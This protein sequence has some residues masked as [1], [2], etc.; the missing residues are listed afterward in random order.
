MIIENFP[1]FKI[2][3]ECLFYFILLVL[4]L[5]IYKVENKDKKVF[6]LL[7]IFKIIIGILFYVSRD[8]PFGVNTG[9]DE[10]V[11]FNFAKQYLNNGEFPFFAFTQMNR[12]FVF[13]D[14]LHFILFNEANIMFII[15][16]NIFISIL[17][18]II[19]YE[20]L[21]N[22]FEKKVT[23]IIIFLSL[24]P[25]VMFQNFENM[26]DT[27]ILFFVISFVKFFYKY[28]QVGYVNYWYLPFLAYVTAILR[29]YNVLVEA[30]KEVS[31]KYN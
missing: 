14:W 12:G 31:A 3:I 26:R 8:N 2:L 1:G 18:W 29:F 7:F 22:L 11:Y 13:Y 9:N 6:I 19:F 20:Q 17:T 21:K 28:L 23:Y 30:A 10:L 5:N 25:E 15:V 16:S 4:I 27:L 24:I